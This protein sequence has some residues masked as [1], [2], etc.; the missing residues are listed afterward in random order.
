MMM[1]PTSMS[2]GGSAEAWCLTALIWLQAMYIDVVRKGAADDLAEA[3]PEPVCFA[4]AVLLDTRQDLSA[5]R[6]SK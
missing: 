3:E 2:P 6:A 1:L 5:Y 4:R